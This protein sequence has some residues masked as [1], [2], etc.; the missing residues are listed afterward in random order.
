MAP[1]ITGPQPGELSSDEVLALVDFAACPEG[2]THW[3]MLCDGRR[4]TSVWLQMGESGD[5]RVLGD[6]P[7]FGV[8]I[9]KPLEGQRHRQII[10]RRGPQLIIPPNEQYRRDLLAREKL[11]K[12][13]LERKVLGLDEIEA[14]ANAAGEAADAEDEPG[15]LFWNCQHC[16]E[17]FA[18]VIVM[19]IAEKRL[20]IR[21]TKCKGIQH[22]LVL[23]IVVELAEPEEAPPGAPPA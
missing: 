5:V 11:E 15:A 2:T 7:A 6:A 20:L 1:Q 17:N 4:S 19:E 21:C 12:D 23:G 10:V 13:L 9:G 8:P 14:G 22:E 3:S 18:Y 16:G